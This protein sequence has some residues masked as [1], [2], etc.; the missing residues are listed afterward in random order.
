MGEHTWGWNG[1]DTREGG[2]SNADFAAERRSDEQYK[3]AAQTWQEQRAFVPNA[4]A[5][6][7]DGALKRAILADWDQLRPGRFNESGFVAVPAS[8]QFL[9][10]AVKIGF[11]E[12]TG[13]RQLRHHF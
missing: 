10:G 6:L 1:G 4:V 12:T 2:W 3:T 11:D 8:Q 7:G 13:V 9:C 5:A